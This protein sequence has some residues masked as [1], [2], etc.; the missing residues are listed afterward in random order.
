MRSEDEKTFLTAITTT[1]GLVQEES[2]FINESTRIK[3]ID[4][5][6]SNI[7]EFDPHLLKVKLI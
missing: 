1:S 6:K 4:L 2:I 3:R 7:S 5:I